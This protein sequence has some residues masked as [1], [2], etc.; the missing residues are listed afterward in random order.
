MYSS[1]DCSLLYS[2][3]LH[4]NDRDVRS[5]FLIALLQRKWKEDNDI[6]IIEIDS[7]VTSGIPLHKGKLT[8]SMSVSLPKRRKP[9]AS[10]AVYFAFHSPKTNLFHSITLPYKGIDA[11][12]R[13]WPCFT[14]G[15]RWNNTNEDRALI[16]AKNATLLAFSELFSKFTSL[17][18]VVAVDL[19]FSKNFLLWRSER[20]TR[21]FKE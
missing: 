13:S 3:Q 1:T 4:M 19:A 11:T 17:S 15:F 21:F 12:V 10:M 9:I 5:A 16:I 6:S 8:K 14:V 20:S 7:V 18:F 2:T